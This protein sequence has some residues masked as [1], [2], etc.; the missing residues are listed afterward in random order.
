MAGRVGGER[1]QTLEPI[2]ISL[3]YIDANISMDVLTRLRSD[4]GPLES[5]VRYF[6]SFLS[7]YPFTENLRAPPACQQDIDLSQCPTNDLILPMC[8]PHVRIPVNH[9][10]PLVTCNEDMSSC[11]PPR[12]N[13]SVGVSDADYVIYVTAQQ[14]GN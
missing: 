8:G 6:Q 7:V 12:G 13:E 10:G 4:D 14:D 5:A 11:L 9:T 2:R 1:Q 3:Q